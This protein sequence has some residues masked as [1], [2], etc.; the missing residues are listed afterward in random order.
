MQYSYAPVRAKHIRLLKPVR[1]TGASNNPVLTFA[2]ETYNITRAPP[3]T[4]VSYVWGLAAASRKILLD[5]HEFAIRQNLWSCLYHLALLPRADSYHDSLWTNIWVDAICINQHEEKEKSR[6]V[7]AMDEVYS[8]AVEVSA[9]LGPQRLP[10]WM[11]WREDGAEI[12][13]SN[14]WFLPENILEIA[15]RPYWSRTWIVQELLLAHRVC[16]HVGDRSF[17]FTQLS[18]E[19]EERRKA[20]S[21]DL[22]QLLAFVDAREM[23][24]R[25]SP[26]Y[27][28]EILLQFKDCQCLDPRDKVFALLSLLNEDDKRNLGRCFP[29][30]S[31]IHDAVVVIT[32]SYLQDHY[33]QSITC[34]SH[35]IFD[36]LGATSSRL[37]R[38]RLLEAST[39]LHTFSNLRSISDADFKE[40]PFY[41][42]E[43]PAWD[44]PAHGQRKSL[45]RRVAVRVWWP[46]LCCG[47]LFY[48]VGRWITTPHKEVLTL[49]N[50]Q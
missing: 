44:Q 46:V 29:D 39:T 4:A 18:W 41:W 34:N 17:D 25:Y 33:D 40:I 43:G 50:Q 8:N 15:E 36:S 5:G 38:R 13:Q 11:Q 48:F 30:Y 31:L 10:N 32:L 3:Y 12:P 37:M 35:E 24:N 14:S 16:V 45:V 26:R 19:V 21:E 7:R 9:W 1:Q 23:T 42:W 6:Q 47:A 27:L 22:K 49:P 20:D 2:V 28:N